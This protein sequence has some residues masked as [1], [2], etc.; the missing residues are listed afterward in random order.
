MGTVTYYNA[1][2]IRYNPDTCRNP[3]HT[4]FAVTGILGVDP[5]CLPVTDL[6]IWDPERV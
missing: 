1:N 5:W 3:S 2:R 4:G 6:R